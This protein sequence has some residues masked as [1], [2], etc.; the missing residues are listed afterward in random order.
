MEQQLKRLNDKQREAVTSID[1]P[2]L[3]LA[4]AG[5]GKTTVLTT[6]IAYILQNTYAQPWN[7][8]A[9]TFTNK[10]ANEMKTRI[11]AIIGDAVNDMWVGTFHSICVK[12]LRSCIERENYGKDFIIYDSADSRTVVKECVKELGLDEKEFPPRS[13]LSVISNAKNDML[14]ADDFE[15]RYGSDLRLKRIA[16]LYKLYQRKLKNNNALDFDD[17]IFL[18]VKILRE[19]TDVAEKYQAR[20]QYILV[21]EYQDTNNSQYELISIIARG[22][23][24]VCVVGDDDQSIYK[25]RGANV[26]N[27]LGFES[28]YKDAKKI[29]LEQ[30]YRS[31]DVILDAANAVIDNN[32]KRMGK[33]L[34]TVKEDGEKII[35]FTGRDERDE[36][37]FVAERIARR[38]KETHKYSD[39]AVLYRTN[40]QSRA[41]EEGLMRE[42][43]PYRVLGG[44]R[45]YDRKE[46]KDVIAY[47]R[48]VYNYHDDVSFLRIVNEPKR[49]IGTATLD[50]LRA[51]N[52]KEGSSCF[53]VAESAVQYPDLR[54][55]A[56]RLTAF[57]DFI[58]GMRRAATEV[59][60]YELAKMIIDE[61][62]YRE[63]LV[64]EGTV[65]SQTRL[66]NVEE[67][68]N[69]VKEF[70]DDTENTGSLGE[71]LESVTLVS[72]IDSY[73][74]TQDYVV[75][76]TIHSAKG[77]EFPVVFLTGLEEGLF[78]GVK[79]IMEQ[80]ELEEERRLCYVAITR[81]KELLYVTSAN[82]RLKFGQL[83]SCRR[84]R[85]FNEIPQE[86]LD[87]ISCLPAKAARK[88]IEHGLEFVKYRDEYKSEKAGKSF[89]S[90]VTT[91]GGGG[92]TEYHFEPGDRVRHRKFGEG[93]VMKSQTFGKDAMVQINFESVG[94][95]QLMAAFAKLEKID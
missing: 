54:T 5:S 15:N 70:S 72:D 39:C 49:K 45:F 60:I 56:S 4:G 14:S 58:K 75:L 59:D 79:S 91:M 63:M 12:I 33:K 94:V 73:D 32:K 87:D 61:S 47:M 81:A 6:R 9:I 92:G 25:F 30:N 62:G 88:S 18:T 43:I 19:N 95:K 77:L 69:V 76:M 90:S 67:F 65:E 35:G 28:D 64:N 53:E 2:L 89:I 8:L 38:Y 34:W 71:F 86:L 7:I 83:E 26:N 52:A 55:A 20:F 40:A 16:E 85:F 41:L 22:Y 68:L 21:D 3:V 29:M 31:T 46:I 17:I 36:A 44:T 11:Q 24:N 48:L 82:C 37:T 74:E 80:E 57:T 13:V 78:P 1:G 10:A 27:I 50:K 51:H 84:S 42:A 23:G 93:V 66:E